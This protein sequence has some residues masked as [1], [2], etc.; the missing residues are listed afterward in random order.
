MKDDE[1]V[2]A[3]YRT[4]F[5]TVAGQKVLKDLRAQYYDT[6]SLA[7]PGDAHTTT[8]QAAQR[9]VIRYILDEIGLP[10]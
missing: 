7:V 8:I 3:D 9:D 2:R 5:G 4:V 10:E 6:A 1:K